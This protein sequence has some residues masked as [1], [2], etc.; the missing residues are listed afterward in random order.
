MRSDGRT[1]LLQLPLPPIWCRYYGSEQ[2]MKGVTAD[3]SNRAPLWERGFDL[4]HP[5]YQVRLLA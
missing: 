4:T 2:G 5:N 1:S 3:S